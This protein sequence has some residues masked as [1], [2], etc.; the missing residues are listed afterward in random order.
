MDACLGRFF[1][2]FIIPSGDPS[3]AITA[4]GNTS[5]SK[6]IPM[7]I[8]V[9]FRVSVVSANNMNHILGRTV[10]K[11]V[12]RYTEA[13]MSELNIMNALA[14]WYCGAASVSDVAHLMYLSTNVSV[15]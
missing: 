13:D 4:S 6:S 8:A 14:W 5:N 2:A 7:S 3:F 15:A 1:N 10:P 11:D 9:D 12:G